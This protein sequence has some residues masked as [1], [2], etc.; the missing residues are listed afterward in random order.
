MTC[1][2]DQDAIVPLGVVLEIGESSEDAIARCIFTEHGS[3]FPVRRHATQ[4]FGEFRN[5]ALCVRE[6]LGRLGRCIVDSNQQRA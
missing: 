2:V 4:D 6:P 5:V 3:D 1:V